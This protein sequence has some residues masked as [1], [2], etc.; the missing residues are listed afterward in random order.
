MTSGVKKTKRLI[1]SR[2]ET[3]VSKYPKCLDYG[4]L[5]LVCFDLVLVRCNFDNNWVFSKTYQ[6]LAKYLFAFRN[7]QKMKCLN[8]TSLCAVF[9]LEDNV[10]ML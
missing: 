2:E 8:L 1:Y 6:N 3:V 7:S 10:E 9:L 5:P 4:F